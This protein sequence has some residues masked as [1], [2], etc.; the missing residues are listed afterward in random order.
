[1]I[2]LL[3][4]GV[5]RDEGGWLLH[6]VCARIAPQALTVIVSREPPERQALL[7]VISG[8][9]LPDEGRVW[10]DGSAITRRT[11]GRLPGRLAWVDLAAPLVEQRTVLYNVLRSEQPL[12]QRLTMPT[13]GRRAAAQR[14]LTAVR[15]DA[16]ALTPAGGLGPGARIRLGQPQALVNQPRYLLIEIPSREGTGVND[17]VRVHLRRLTEAAR[18]AVLAATTAADPIVTLADRVVALGDGLLLY[19]GPAIGFAAA[20][21][22]H[23]A[24][25]G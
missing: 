20:R 11:G 7:D 22:R 17:E 14:A 23:R 3:G 6:R 15:L 25:L 8:R 1:M 5:P 10:V 9:R 13:P 2:E 4:V 18:V 16:L 19:D 21:A 12:Y 24:A